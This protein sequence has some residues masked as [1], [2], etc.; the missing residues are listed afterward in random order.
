[1]CSSQCAL[2]KHGEIGGTTWNSKRP[3][4]VCG[5]LQSRQRAGFDG[6]DRIDADAGHS[7]EIDLADGQ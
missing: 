3:G 7:R 1:M 4:N 2:K 5:D 6:D